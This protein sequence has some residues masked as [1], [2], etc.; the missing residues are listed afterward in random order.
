VPTG[1]RRGFSPPSVIAGDFTI[2]PLLKSDDVI[3]EQAC[4]PP[5][6]PEACQEV[7]KDLRQLV[8][9]S[10][11]SKIEAEDLLDLLEAAGYE[12]CELSFVDGEGFSVR[13]TSLQ[14]QKVLPPVRT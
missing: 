2:T 11:L 12:L 4:A 5:R 6:R 8:E 9:V 10:G 3:V 13:P 14:A 7:S 1:Q